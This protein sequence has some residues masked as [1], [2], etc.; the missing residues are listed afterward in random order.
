MQQLIERCGIDPRYRILLADQAFIGELDGD[1]QCCFRGALAAAG[2]QHPQLALFDREL[3]VLH[4]A[5]MLFE[6]RV[7]PRQFLERLGHRGFHRCL[8]GAGLLARVFGDVLRD[9]GRR[10]VAHIAE[11]HRLH[12]DRGAPGLRNVMQPPVGHRARV[13]PG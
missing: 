5:V 7:D 12:V 1:P 13:H 11:H 10:G 2:L 3:H 9:A 4:V 6:Q 8:V